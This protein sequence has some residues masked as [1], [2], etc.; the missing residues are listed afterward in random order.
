MA[1]RTAT[2]L[3]AGA[4]GCTI[5]DL[6]AR[7]GADV[8][9]WDPSAE[10]IESLRAERRPK[11]VPELEMHEGIAITG[12]LEGAL[13]GSDAAVVV[14]PSQA[15]EGLSA[16]LATLPAGSRPRIVVL[17]SKGI[18]IASRRL[19][20]DVVIAH[21]PEAA[22]A[23]LT[24]PCIAREVARRIP[25]S[26]VVASESEEAA[27][28][29]QTAFSTKWF[30]VYRQTDVRGVELGGALKNVIAIGAGVSDGLGFGDNSKSALLCRGLAEMMRLAVAMG[31]DERTM[32]GLAGLGD[33]AVTCFSPHSRNRR[34]GDLIARGRTREEAFAEI[35]QVVEGVPTAS[36]AHQLARELGVETPIIDVVHEMCTG[37]KT[38]KEGLASLMAR[39]LKTEF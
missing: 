37:A 21:L 15:V 34:F 7:A 2:V 20:S 35:G 25:T 31:A 33:L 9:L 36:A 6:L 10:T 19:L 27:T 26:V 30:R 23:V 16:K 4:W 13:S 5:A 11:F 39:G 18:D 22:V 28:E 14:A 12:D 29:L 3:A 17:A 1:I 8:R 38:P 24:G 32:S